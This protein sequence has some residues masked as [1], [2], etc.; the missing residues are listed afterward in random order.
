MV[1]WMH[2]HVILSSNLLSSMKVFVKS[3]VNNFL[4]IISSRT[5]NIADNFQILVI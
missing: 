4:V 2:F 5:D 1:C 3:P